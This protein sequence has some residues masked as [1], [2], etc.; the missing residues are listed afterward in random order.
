MARKI[1]VGL[2]IGNRLSREGRE[3]LLASQPDIDVVW[4]EADG[5]IALNTLPEAT[6]DVV[7]VDSRLKSVSGIDF[8][9]RYLMRQVGSDTRIPKFVLSSP[10]TGPE[11]AID[12]IRSGASDFV[13]DESSAEELLEAVRG[14]DIEEPTADY[15]LL[16]SLFESQGITRGSYPR[17]HLR[18]GE[19]QDRETKVFEALAGGVS[20]AALPTHL[21]YAESTIRSS[22]NEIKRVLGFGTSVQLALAAYEAGE[23]TDQQAD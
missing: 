13:S 14:A 18:M 3:L 7:L 2:L 23:L 19:L 10:F 16:A 20:E 6:V 21:G 22:I 8:I 9:S 4:Q 5:E 11:L 17:W 15:E 12:A 1:R